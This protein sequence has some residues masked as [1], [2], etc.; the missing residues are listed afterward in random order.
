MNRAGASNGACPIEHRTAVVR[1]AHHQLSVLPPITRSLT[2]KE[3][4]RAF[5]V[6]QPSEIGFGYVV[7]VTKHNIL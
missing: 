5:A 1:D 6:E 2:P 7:H 3:A 4:D